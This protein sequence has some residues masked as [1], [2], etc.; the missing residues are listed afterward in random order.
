VFNYLFG[1]VAVEGQSLC[2]HFCQQL[3]E[4]NGLSNGTIDD[5]IEKVI[6]EFIR[7]LQQ[8]R[9]ARPGLININ[10]LIHILKLNALKWWRLS[11]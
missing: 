8:F 6:C 11:W 3:I 5:A 10:H 9:T 1:I 2:P 4:L 7:P